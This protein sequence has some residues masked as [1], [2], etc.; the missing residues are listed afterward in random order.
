M[1]VNPDDVTNIIQ[2]VFGLLA[3]VGLPVA[4]VGA[5]VVNI[6][7]G[8]VGIRNSRKRAKRD[9]DNFNEGENDTSNS[10]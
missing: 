2:G 5:A 10:E 6:A 9:K 7:T 4:A 3:L 1:Q 8:I